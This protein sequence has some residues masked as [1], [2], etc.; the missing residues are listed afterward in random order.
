MK[1]SNKFTS[2]IPRTFSSFS[3]KALVMAVLSFSIFS[4]KKSVQVSR[5]F[6]YAK[7][8]VKCAKCNV[9]YESAGQTTNF[10]V[11]GSTAVNYIRYDYDYNLDLNIQSLAADQPIVLGVY[12]RTG[13]QVILNTSVRKENEIWNSKIFIP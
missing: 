6:G 10:T 1:Q 9:S 11:E 3:K 4:C 7:V 2:M 8:T 13:K 12:S 5:D